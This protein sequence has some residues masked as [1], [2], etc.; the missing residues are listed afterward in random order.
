VESA[1]ARALQRL[2]HDLELETHDLDVHLNRRDSPLRAGHL[3][4]HV[5][6]VIL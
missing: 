5:T 3:E 4:V 6:E 1:L 2:L